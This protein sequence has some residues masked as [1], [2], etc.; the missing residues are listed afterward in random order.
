MFKPT[1]RAAKPKPDRAG[2]RRQF[3][4]LR[5]LRNPNIEEEDAEGRVLLIITPPET[6]ASKILGF[7]L[8]LSPEERKKRVVLDPIGSHV[9]RLCDGRNSIEVISKSLQK[10]FKLGTLEAEHSLRQ[11]FQ[12]LGKRG[13]VGFVQE[14]GQKPKAKDQKD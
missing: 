5:P 13:Y 10:T 11:F 9:W 4:S 1:K 3:L 2:V 7:F 8:P 6:R 12:T 14:K